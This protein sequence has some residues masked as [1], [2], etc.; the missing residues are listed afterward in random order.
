MRKLVLLVAVVVIVSV[1][2]TPVSAATQED[3]WPEECD[4]A[5]IISD[6]EIS[7]ELSTSSDEDSFRVRFQEGQ[8][9]DISTDIPSD[10]SQNPVLSMFDNQGDGFTRVSFGDNL[11]IRG[12]QH[13]TTNDLE[14][15]LLDGSKNS[16]S[17]ELWAVTNGFSENPLCITVREDDDEEWETPYSWELTIERSDPDVTLFEVR[18]LEDRIVELQNRLDDAGERVSEFESKLE[19]KN[20]RINNLQSRVEELESQSSGG[21]A[22]GD[23]TITVT[24]DPANEQENFVEGGQAIVQADSES[25]DVSDIQVE[26]GDGT[27]EMDS[28]GE[29]LIPLAQTGT[30]EVSLVY[31]DTTEQV[32]IDVQESGDSQQGD[33]RP[34]DD[35]QQ[36][37]TGGDN[38]SS[39][40]GPGFGI[41]IGV[42]A[43]VSVAAILR[44]NR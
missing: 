15:I 27:Y 36:Q 31:G 2:A 20:E 9:L 6:E 35:S 23:V 38:G 40:E 11:G 16:H 18:Q 4:E 24:V 29:V 28:S 21:S 3:E 39:G 30:Q 19:E 32:S 41:V 8:Y 42:I 13:G 7:G 12:L 25:A 1:G 5:P 43:L 14:Q 34:S 10:K 44:M 33:Y 22:N 17:V 26:Y 37:S